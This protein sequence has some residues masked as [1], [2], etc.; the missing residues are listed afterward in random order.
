MFLSRAV[1]VQPCFN[2]E[3]ITHLSDQA[4]TNLLDLGAWAEGDKTQYSVASISDNVPDQP[5]GQDDIDLESRIIRAA[6]SGYEDQIREWLSR[7][8]DTAATRAYVTRVLL[9]VADEAPN[10]ILD[11][12]IDSGLTD[13]RHQHD[14]N[15]RNCLHS[16]A[17]SGNILLLRKGIAGGSDIVGKDIY[18]RM[19]LHYGCIDG[20]VDIIECL[21]SSNPEMVDIKDQDGFTPLMHAIIN[22]RLACARKLFEYGAQVD[23]NEDSNGLPNRVPLNL[24]C[25]CSTSAVVEMILQRNPKIVADTDGLFPQHLVAQS[26]KYPSL[27]TTLK[28][29]GV[30]LDQQDRF[31]QWT[32]LIHAAK[33]GHVKILRALLA[34]G[35]TVDSLDE[36]GFSAL[37]YATLESHLDCMT[38]LAPK[39]TIEQPIMELPGSSN[40]SGTFK[41]HSVPFDTAAEGIPP[42]SLPPPIIPLRRYGHNFLDNK[43]FVVITFDGESSNPIE[44]YD[45]SKYP[46]AR[47]MIT[48]KSSD[49]VPRSLLLPIQYEL[50]TISFQIEN[51]ETFSLEFDIYPLSGTKLIA[52]T[53]A[54]SIIFTSCFD[55]CGKWH[56]EFLDPRLKAVG[57]IT[58]SFRVLKPFSS[59]PIEITNL[60]TYWK[61]TSQLDLSQNPLV[62]SSSLSGEYIRL[63]LQMTADGEIV[64]G[65]RTELSCL[66]LSVPLRA[67][68]Y[69]QLRHI[70]FQNNHIAK[71]IAGEDLQVD[72]SKLNDQLKNS[73]LT[74]RHVLKLL[75][76]TTHL[77]LHILQLGAYTANGPSLGSNLN[78]NYFADMVLSV[79]FEHSMEFK[80]SSGDNS[81][82]ILF[83]SNDETICLALNWKQPN[84][85]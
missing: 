6:A 85:K 65:Q 42:I 5:F 61:V 11:A 35:V 3:V 13:L 34:F 10:V 21:L 83:T 78:V 19:A 46:A 67:L 4:L 37:Y 81:R 1:E 84:C 8:S 64:V 52:R 53:V 27:I 12:L 26:G 44:L 77:E 72:L 25:Q 20:N 57:R 7:L 23:P 74:L 33:E 82:S 63:Y 31:Y 51:L 28:N 76:L 54:S 59:T 56:L 62:T 49:L 66:G 38:A 32:P 58:F 36:K 60:G 18:G 17:I 22:S 30:D 68:T 16:A 39:R 71:H 55:D 70:L 29:Y 73:Y 15:G 48:S 2:R 9:G 79:V 14:I 69:T 24:A 41:K 40:V 45:N 50:K 43:T 80:A 75:P 47:L